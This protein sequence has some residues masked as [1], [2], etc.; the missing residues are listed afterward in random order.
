MINPKSKEA[1]VHE[2]RMQSLQEATM[3]VIARKGITGATMQDIADEAG[4]AKGT[5]YLYYRDRDELVEKTFEN[6][7]SEL[8]RRVDA[9]LDADAPLEERLRKS[10]YEA[11]EFFRENGQFF[12]LYIAQRFP[13]GTPQQQAKQKR[14]CDQYRSRMVKLAAIFEEA[15]NRGEIRRVDPY[16]LAL[17]FAEGTNAI[18]VERVME[19]DPPP[20]DAD[21][22]LIVSAILDG[23]R[24]QRS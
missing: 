1:V 18:I 24:I 7:V 13:E 12:R 8:H 17:F 2:F 5:I 21:A 9:V 10:L 15:M 19:Q 23:V 22:D 20:A 14:H 4:V 11:I 3:R 16:R 6:A